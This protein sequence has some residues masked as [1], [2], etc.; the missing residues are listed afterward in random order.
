MNNTFIVFR[1]GLCAPSYASST[2]AT[3]A[4]IIRM[5]FWQSFQFLPKSMLLY[6]GG[7]HATR[8]MRTGLFISADLNIGAPLE[9]TLSQNES[10]G[11]GLW[12][13][14]S[15]TCTSSGE[16]LITRSV[17]HAIYQSVRV[18]YMLTCSP[19]SRVTNIV[20]GALAITVSF[21]VW[22]VS[23]ASSDVGRAAK[24]SKMSLRWSA[25]KLCKPI[26]PEAGSPSPLTTW[27]L[28]L[29]APLA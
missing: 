23:A 26:E 16:M 5:G 8:G 6:P 1:L 10:K 28:D 14:S 13:S 21:G 3:K 19:F 2:S 4:S 22:S 18:W 11:P 15:I 25:G 9:I 27:Q 17:C 12:L 29:K 7:F 20:T 24:L